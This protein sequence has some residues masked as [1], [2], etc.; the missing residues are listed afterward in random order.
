MFELTDIESETLRQFD[1]F[2]NSDLPDDVRKNMLEKKVEF[3]KQL[4]Y[5][6]IEWYK[7]QLEYQ[8]NDNEFILGKRKLTLK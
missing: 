7:I 6:E 3:F 4:H 5:Q 1:D 8:K 2:I